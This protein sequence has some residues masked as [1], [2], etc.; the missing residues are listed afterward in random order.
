VERVKLLAGAVLLAGLV[1]SSCADRTSRPSAG[2]FQIVKRS[3]MA[4]SD[5]DPLALVVEIG[6][7][8]KLRLNKIET[9]NMND[10]KVLKEKLG[11]IFEDREEDGISARKVVV[12]LR[13]PI[14]RPAL[15]VLAA[16]LAAADASPVIVIENG[17]N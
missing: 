6:H 8:L 10:L 17:N 7:D 11:V 9:G 4:A 15:E 13:V 5:A 1:Q 2:H 3:E 14:D 16:Q 12:D